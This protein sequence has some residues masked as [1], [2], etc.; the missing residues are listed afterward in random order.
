MLKLFHPIFV[1]L[2]WR[3]TFTIYRIRGIF[4]FLHDFLS[5]KKNRI[6]EQYCSFPFFFVIHG[7]ARPTCSENEFHLTA[8]ISEK[9]WQVVRHRQY[10]NRV[11]IRPSWPVSPS[12]FRTAHV[13][14]VT[15]LYAICWHR[16]QDFSSD[17]CSTLKLLANFVIT[18]ILSENNAK[19]CYS[20]PPE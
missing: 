7:Y 3:R 2:H 1:D 8:L 15:R 4:A 6:T 16:E 18:L 19:N 17:N 11:A 10:I 13:S 9:F 12:T 5:K 14:S 20:T